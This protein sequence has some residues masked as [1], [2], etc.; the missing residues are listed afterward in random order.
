[1]L[2]TFGLLRIWQL[3]VVA[4]LAGAATLFEAVAAQSFTPM[5]VPFGLRGALIV[6]SGPMLAGTSIALVSPLRSLRRLPVPA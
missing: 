2:A 4:G 3:Y 1:M 6:S 5:L